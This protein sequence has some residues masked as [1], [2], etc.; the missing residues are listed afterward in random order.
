MLRKNIDYI[1]LCITK[2]LFKNP[3]ISKYIMYF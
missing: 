3:Y 2:F 1:I